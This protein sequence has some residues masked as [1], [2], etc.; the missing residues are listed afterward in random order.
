M[1][2]P[3][4]ALQRPPMGLLPLLQMAPLSLLLME[5]RIWE[6]M[7]FLRL[8]EKKEKYGLECGG[9]GRFL[10]VNQK[11][12]LCRDYHDIPWL[13]VFFLH[14]RLY[15]YARWLC[16]TNST[17]LCCLLG[18]KRNYNST[19]LARVRMA[20]DISCFPFFIPD[21][22]HGLWNQLYSL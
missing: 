2:M 8:G 9:H 6:W 3:P 16:G 21:N 11:G 7:R 15:Y 5:A 4:T 10:A 18:K 20:M 17:C 14:H 12:G 1:P 22:F 13:C 19:S